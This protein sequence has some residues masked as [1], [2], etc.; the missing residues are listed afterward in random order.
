MPNEGEWACGSCGNGSVRMSGSLPTLMRL[1]LAEILKA[2]T[3][4]RATLLGTREPLK[5]GFINYWEKGKWKKGHGDW[6]RECVPLEM[7]WSITIGGFIFRTV[8]VY[9]CVHVCRKSV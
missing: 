1:P 9:G 8:C 6:R 4:E 5:E 2:K 7:Q 3:K